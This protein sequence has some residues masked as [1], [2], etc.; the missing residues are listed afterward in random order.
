MPS[1]RAALSF[2]ELHQPLPV[3]SV[4]I[5]PHAIDVETVTQDHRKLPPRRAEDPSTPFPSLAA[6]ARE[7]MTG[8][9]VRIPVSMAD[10]L[11][12]ICTRHKIDQSAL[13]RDFIQ[14]GL[15]EVINKSAR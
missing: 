12:S 4:T 14:A 15:R 6:P 1:E 2:H 7:R 9:S 5:E 10:E 11:E 13:I 3:R 8:L